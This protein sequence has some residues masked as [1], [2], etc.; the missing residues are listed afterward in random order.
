MF[1]ELLIAGH[2]QTYEPKP[3]PVQEI[4]IEEVIEVE[5]PTQ[6]EVEPE[7]VEPEITPPELTLQEKIATNYYQCDTTTQYIRAD[8]AQCL[9]KPVQIPQPARNTAPAAPKTATRNNGWRF[10]I[11]QCTWWVAT[12]RQV[13][14]WNNATDW[15][16]QAKRDGYA[17][18]SQPRPGAIAWRVGHVAYVQSVSGSTMTVSEANYDRRGSI[19][20]ITV[21]T[22]SYSSFIY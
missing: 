7:P 3:E 13:G 16:W 4:K 11:G 19:R 20:T 2:F 14:N 8:N 22:N 12:K 15:L 10:P 1:I 5:E 17:T 21:P 18:G 6:I 9:A